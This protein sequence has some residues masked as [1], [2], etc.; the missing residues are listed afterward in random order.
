MVRARA[1]VKRLREERAAHHVERDAAVADQLE[2]PHARVEGGLEPAPYRFELHQQAGGAAVAAE[3]F[4]HQRVTVDQREGPASGPAGAFRA[5]AI[6]VELH[7]WSGRVSG[8]S[9]GSTRPASVR[10]PTGGFPP[11]PPASHVSASDRVVTS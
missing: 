4:E 8:G 9:I 11:A 7:G 10:S 3:A 6:G 5:R 2:L 1:D